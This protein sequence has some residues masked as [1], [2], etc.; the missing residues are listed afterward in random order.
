MAAPGAEEEGPWS[1]DVV[2]ELLDRAEE[3]VR[4][5]KVTEELL[6]RISRLRPFDASYFVYLFEKWM[7]E[8]RR[9]LGGESLA[10]A[11]AVEAAALPR[12]VEWLRKVAGVELPL[13]ARRGWAAEV[14][15][16]LGDLVVE[17]PWEAR[18]RGKDEYLVKSSYT[19]A[20]GGAVTSFSGVVSWGRLKGLLRYVPARE[21]LR[22]GGWG[23]PTLLDFASSLAEV[24]DSYVYVTVAS[25]RF[26]DGR[27]EEKIEVSG[28]LL[29]AREGAGAALWALLNDA[30]IPPSELEFVKV[31]RGLRAR[32]YVRLRWN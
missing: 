7:Y 32:L 21:L 18:L 27:E 11:S 5:G 17:S 10:A 22:R 28:A 24:P 6:A 15:G 26:E 13:E 3:Q 23:A 12:V 1:I 31:R 8:N 4:Q 19:G 14:V 29:P 30:V 2:Y 16:R 20:S 9:G 25:E